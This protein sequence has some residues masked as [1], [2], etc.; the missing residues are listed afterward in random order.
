MK[1]LFLPLVFLYSYYTNA[2]NICIDSSSHFQYKT[3]VNDSFRV[4][5]TILTK[6]SSKISIGFFLNGVSRSKAFISKINSKGEVSWFKKITAPFVSGIAELENIEEAANGNIFVTFIRGQLDNKPFFYLVFSP[7][8]NLLFQNKFGLPNNQI[9]LETATI[10]TSLVSKFGADSMLMV[11]IHPVNAVTSDGMTLLTVSNNGQIGQ[12]ITYAPPMITT[13]SSYYSKCKI[14]GNNIFLY[15][16]TQFVNT[17]MI[18]FFEQPAYA[19]LQIDWNTKQVASKKIFCSPPIGF[20]QFGNPLGLGVDNENTSIFIQA[21]GNIIFTRRIWGL[22]FNGGDTLTR[23][24]NIS[25]F[26]SSF[27]HIKSEYITTP[28]RFKWWLDWDYEMYIDSIDTRHLLIHDLP[29]QQIY[30]AMGNQVNQYFLQ[31]KTPQIATRKNIIQKSRILEFGY[32]TSFD[33]VS[34]DNNQTYIDNF[35]ILEKDTAASCF[36]TNTSFLNSKPATVSPIN[37]QGNFTVQQAVIES[38]PTNFILEDYPLQRTIICNI[39]NKCDAIKINAPDTVCNISQPV[40]ITAHKN[41]LCNGKVNFTFDTTQVQSFLQINDTTLSLTFNKS[42]Q[43]KIFARPGSCDKLIDS[44]TLNVFAPGNPIDLGKDTIYCSGKTYTLN[45]YNPDFKKYLWQDGSTDSIFTATTHGTYYVTATD[46]CNRRYS[47]TIKITNK[48]YPLNIGK[49]SAICK[50]ESI[51]LSVPSG[52]LNYNWQ[53]QYNITSIAPNR[54][55]VNPEVNTSY[56]VEAEVF[57]GCK[58]SDTINIKVEN[59]TQYI[60]FP[61]SFTPNNDGLNDTFK[62]LIGGAMTK[63]ELQIYNRWGQL[64][65]RTTN[66]NE[67]WSGKLKGV[68]QDNGTFVWLCKYQFYGKPEKLIKGTVNIIR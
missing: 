39:V 28:R 52:Y 58:L 50:S 62:P 9:N 34:S 7:S 2:Q 16:S 46:F 64:V 60:Y 36:G 10:T 45:A 13:Y 65:F 42:W 22:D 54:V 38:A 44:V 25:T 41:P 55:N 59:C 23:I 31:K 48:T 12:G 57:T 20:D 27:N 8:G 63:Y 61:N 53:P 51:L 6:D 29:N 11:L 4:Q 56:R 47:D 17:C 21:N 19:K 26:D 40:I 18:N 24:F 3:L 15:G 43:G 35:R 1:Y 67:G 14:E 33:I 66:K 32:F 5:K 30:Y 37:W 68:Q 49:D